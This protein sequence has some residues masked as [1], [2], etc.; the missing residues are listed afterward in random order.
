MRY[1]SWFWTINGCATRTSSRSTTSSWPHRSSTGSAA[2]V[3]R[4][5]IFDLNLL[6]SA[7]GVV[8]VE[9]E[10]ETVTSWTNAASDHGAVWAE[11]DV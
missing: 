3:E 4:R 10:Y 8:D 2:G 5:G 9:R 1:A 11:F 6:T 7:S